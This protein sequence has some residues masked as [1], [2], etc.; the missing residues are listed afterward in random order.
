MEHNT[1]TTSCADKHKR[2]SRTRSHAINKRTHKSV[3][4]CV[5]VCERE[6]RGEKHTHK[7]NGPSKDAHR[8]GRAYTRTRN[9]NNKRNTEN[10]RHS[11]TERGHLG[12]LHHLC[13]RWPLRA[14]PANNRKRRKQGKAKQGGED[15]HNH[16]C[17]NLRLGHL[18]RWRRCHYRL[19]ANG[20]S[21]SACGDDAQHP[22]MHTAA[23]QLC[24]R[25]RPYPSLTMPLL[26]RTLSTFNSN[27]SLFGRDARRPTA[28]TTICTVSSHLIHR[29]VLMQI[30]PRRPP[31]HRHP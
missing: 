23:P 8:E 13:P 11:W 16:E 12:S 10:E 1:S 5:C 20:G 28:S 7:L 21:T 3:H 19:R 6:R 24:Q 9:N 31:T 15:T 2:R 29:T 4:V 30:L 17:E 14:N 22:N 18:S 27:R 26:Q 25:A